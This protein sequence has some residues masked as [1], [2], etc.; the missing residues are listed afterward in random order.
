[1]LYRI[2]YLFIILC[3]F[4]LLC[5]ISLVKKNQL[6]VSKQRWVLISELCVPDMNLQTSQKWL[7]FLWR[8]EG[9][10]LLVEDEESLRH[11]PV[12]VCVCLSVTVDSQPATLLIAFH[13][14]LS[15]E[16]KRMRT[17]NQT[18][19]CIV[20]VSRSVAQPFA[21]R[22]TLHQTSANYTPAGTFSHFL[23]L[24]FS[25]KCASISF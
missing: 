20:P 4:I 15:S 18:H 11:Q 19:R 16:R 10:V 24:L 14:A 9:P 2:C 17:H 25:L 8:R 13:L 21:F 3:I 22:V 12:C 6:T 1:M 23:R 5:F 7:L